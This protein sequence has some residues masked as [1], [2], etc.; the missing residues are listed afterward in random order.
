M[1][2]IIHDDA[3]ALGATAW[4]FAKAKRIPHHPCLDLQAAGRR[5]MTK[6]RHGNDAARRAQLSAWVVILGTRTKGPSRSAAWSSILACSAYRTASSGLQR[7]GSGGASRRTVQRYACRGVAA[8]T[9]WQRG[10]G[11]QQGRRLIGSGG[12]ARAK[13]C[14]GR[15]AACSCPPR[16]LAAPAARPPHRPPA[17]Q[18]QSSMR[19][20]GGKEPWLR[21]SQ[22]HPS[23][24]PRQQHTQECRRSAAGGRKG[25]RRGAAFSALCS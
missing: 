21:S 20:G 16:L 24:Q 17:L 8:Q 13:A 15:T 10:G 1:R 2:R 9:S 6:S 3:G 7:V 25:G 22:M 19:G 23:S 5:Y 12:G 18:P 11:G 14:C 4:S